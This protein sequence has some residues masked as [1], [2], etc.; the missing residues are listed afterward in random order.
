MTS[1]EFW[2]SRGSSD[3]GVTGEGRMENTKCR[4]KGRDTNCT[5]SHQFSERP[6]SCKFV[7]FVSK[8]CVLCSSVVKFE[9]IRVI[10]VN[11]T[12]LWLRLCSAVFSVVDSSDSSIGRSGD[13][14]HSREIAKAA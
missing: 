14:Q 2:N 3:L 10:R 5:N 12:S 9:L 4:S 11:W 6:P 8:P 13:D 7:K 1:S